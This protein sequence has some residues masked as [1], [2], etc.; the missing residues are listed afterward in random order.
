MPLPDHA[1][2]EYTFNEKGQQV[3]KSPTINIEGPGGSFVFD[4]FNAKVRR[5]L[6][7]QF[8]HVEYTDGQGRVQGV[9]VDTD[10]L[11]DLEAQH[12]PSDFSPVVDG[13]TGEWF[14]RHLM[15]DVTILPTD[16][17]H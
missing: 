13:S 1:G 8:D 7:P 5:F 14:I 12:F 17:E 3:F 4:W 10:R 9:I 2:P 15:E 11:A 6:D 16:S